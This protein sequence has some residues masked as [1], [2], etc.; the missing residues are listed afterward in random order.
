MLTEALLRAGARVVSVEL[1]AGRAALLQ[2]RFGPRGAHV[3]PGDLLRVSL[4]DEPYRVLANPPWDLA[5]SILGRLRRSVHCRR[6]DLVLP[7]WRVRRW[8]SRYDGVSH[9]VS[10]RTESFRPAAPY[11]AAVAI[12]R[13]ATT[14]G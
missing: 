11:G 2:R 14:A 10:I 1:H 13:T 6:A 4:P 3:V 12:V 7:R 8:C 9:G 5:D